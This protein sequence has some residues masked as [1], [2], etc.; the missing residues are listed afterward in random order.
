MTIKEKCNQQLCSLIK[1]INRNKI[2]YDYTYTGHLLM[3]DSCQVYRFKLINLY[4][5]EKAKN[6][7]VCSIK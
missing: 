7:P 5:V 3:V 1:L 6:I 2:L 4:H